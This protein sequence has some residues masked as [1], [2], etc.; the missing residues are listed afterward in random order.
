MHET[1]EQSLPGIR[2][3]IDGAQAWIRGIASID[4]PGLADDA[5]T[6]VGM[7][8][9][10]ALHH[11]PARG[12][13]HLKATAGEYGLKIEARDPGNPS[14]HDG[15]EWAEVSCLAWSFRSRRTDA[16]RLTEVEIRARQAA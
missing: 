16:G 14:D 12:T 6:T 9:S 10:I 4:H 7:L 5:A 8:V 1:Y 13:I 11:T 2:E 3:S 15:A